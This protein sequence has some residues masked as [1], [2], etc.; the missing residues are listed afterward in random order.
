MNNRSTNQSPWHCGKGKMSSPS[1]PALK[2]LF[3]GAGAAVLG[4]EDGLELGVFDGLNEGWPEG[5]RVGRTEGV[6]EG[7][8]VLLGACVAGVGS[9]EGDEDGLELG[10]LGKLFDSLSG[11]KPGTG[12]V[13]PRSRA[14]DVLSPSRVCV[15]TIAVTAIAIK[16]VATLPNPIHWARERGI[17]F[18]KY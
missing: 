12:S 2:I 7:S 5:D 1:F 6:P 18:L 4:D 9:A 17:F 3:C 14:D 10:M 11:D 8:V 13:G 16:P 15:R